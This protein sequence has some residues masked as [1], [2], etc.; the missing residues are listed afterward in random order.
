MARLAG[1]V[2]AGHPRHVTQHGNGGNRAFLS[3]SDYALYRDLLGEHCR[4]AEVALWAWCLMPNHVHL[5][6]VPSDVMAGAA[7]SPPCTGELKPKEREPDPAYSRRDEMAKLVG[8][9]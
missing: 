9:V 6:L 1:V 7:R 2:I 4:A 5:V 3:D 8:G